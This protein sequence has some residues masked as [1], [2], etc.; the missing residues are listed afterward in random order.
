MRPSRAN[1]KSLADLASYLLQNGPRKVHHTSRRVRVVLAHRTIVDTT[2]AVHVWEH[3]GYP[4]YYVPQ[5]ELTSRG[6]TLRDKSLV[7]SDSVTR[8]AVVEL[9][10][11]ARDGLREFRTDRVLRFTE[12]RSLGAL[13]GLVRLEFGSMGTNGPPPPL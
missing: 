4:H 5:G 11:P 6:C 13:A 2:A 8:A 10:V 7:R 12:D 1:V 3:D 9:V